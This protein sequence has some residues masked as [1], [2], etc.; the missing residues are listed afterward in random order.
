MTK[1]ALINHGCPKNLIDS[2]L[3]LG[4][5]AKEGL[6]ITLDENEA[7]I[8][9]VN[10]CAFINDAQEESIHSILELVKNNRKVIITGCLPQRYKME[11]H[12]EIPEAVAILGPSDIKKIV[13]VVKKIADNNKNFICEITQKP[14][15]IYP[16]MVERQQITVGASSYLKIA[17]GCNYHCG[18]CI[19]PQLRGEYRSRKI[20]NIVEEAR[21]L[22]Q[23][24]V[25]EIILVAQD[26]TSYGV[27]LYK[28]PSLARLLKELEKV[29]EI[30]WLRVM[31]T[32]PAL[33]TD[34]LIQ[35]FKSSK[36]LVK[37]IDMPV[38]HSHPEILQSMRRPVMDYEALIKKMRAE[39]PDL[40]IRT[41]I[42][43]GYPGEE[44]EHFEHLKNF[45]R[46]IRFD[47]L[48][49]FEYSR[50]KNT[51]AYD[52]EKQ[53]PAKIKKQRKNEIM[54]IQQKI[55]L[56]INKSFIGKEIECIVEATTDDGNIIARSYRDAPE[57]DGLVYVTSANDV[58][59]AD[60]I[61]IKITD[62]DAYDMWGSVV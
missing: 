62:A 37:Y 29:E 8:V 31:Y 33:F 36:K 41:T 45:I 13:E 34:E 49:V 10:T 14:E 24:G 60:I 46:N 3:M 28:K 53:V 47:K 11:L 57:I 2:E 58:L 20:E 4:M 56:K 7:N 30:K 12:K 15:Y 21:S 59:P 61:K 26:T 32:Y 40:A 38:Q 16:E 50:E 51:I 22:A 18:Y 55:S 52:L 44:E 43:V 19:I 5:L 39:I 1:V 6:E 25:N 42:I 54:K 27:D 35:T 9:I 48:G 23:K 17:D